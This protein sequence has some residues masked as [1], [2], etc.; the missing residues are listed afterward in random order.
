M[1]RNISEI[2]CRI[3]PYRNVLTK[4]HQE[5][6]HRG[7]DIKKEAVYRALERG[8]EE[9]ELIFWQQV[10]KVEREA[11]ERK[12]EIAKLRSQSRNGAQ[13]VS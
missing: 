3:Y 6:R 9:V 1:T 5:L 11:E 4:V 8:D 13:A 10:V 2:D 7:R 12:A